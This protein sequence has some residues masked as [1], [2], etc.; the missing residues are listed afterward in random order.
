MTITRLC[1]GLASSPYVAVEALKRTFDQ[2]VWKA[3]F[4][5]K[6][7]E[8]TL[9]FKYYNSLEEINISFIDDILIIPDIF[10]T[11]P[12]TDSFPTTS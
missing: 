10:H 8:L 7:D 9:L 6:K 12:C 4:S 1:Q 2:S 5:K 11:L 3:L